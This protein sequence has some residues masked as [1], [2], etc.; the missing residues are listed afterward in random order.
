[1]PKWQGEVAKRTK[2]GPGDISRRLHRTRTSD[3]SVVCESA[4]FLATHLTPS[5]SFPALFNPR[6]REMRKDGHSGVPSSRCHRCRATRVWR[7]HLSKCPTKWV[8]R[9][10]RH[11]TLMLSGGGLGGHRSIRSESSW[12][13]KKERKAS[14]SRLKL[15]L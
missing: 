14:K 3:L 8:C 2:G 5:Y 9:C 11:P 10:L 1:M 6:R 7:G 12:G 13:E 4:I 15:E